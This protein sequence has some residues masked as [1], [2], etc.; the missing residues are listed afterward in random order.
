MGLNAIKCYHRNP[1]LKGELASIAYRLI[2]ATNNVKFTKHLPTLVNYELIMNA[3]LT[4]VHQIDSK[5]VWGF[6]Q[7]NFSETDNILACVL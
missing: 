1:Q 4:R 5:R 3:Y 2:L 6:S 7:G